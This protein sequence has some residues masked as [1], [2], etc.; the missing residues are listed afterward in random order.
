MFWRVAGFTQ[1]SPVETILD[2]EAFTL[3][4]LLEEDDLIQECKSLNGRL[5]G[6]LQT[7]PTV[8]T[9]L[10]YLV[11]PIAEDADQKRRFKYPFAACEVF[12]CEVDALFSTL[13]EDGDLMKQLLS[14]L[15][16]PGPMDCVQAGYF[17]RVITCVQVKRTQDMMR[18]LQANQEVLA[19]LVS[20]LETTSIAEVIARLVGAEESVAMHLMPQQIA[21][22]AETD[23]VSQLLEALRSAEDLDA[24]KN[25]ANVLAAIARSQLLEALRSAEDLDARKN[26]ANVLAA[27][28]RSQVSPLVQ[29]LVEPAI[30]ERLFEAAF[31]SNVS[32]QALKVCLALLEAKDSPADQHRS[33]QPNAEPDAAASAVHVFDAQMKAATVAGIV[34]YLP[35]L[36]DILD[37]SKAT[38]TQETPFGLLSPPLGL[39]RLK[40]VELAASI[41]HVKIAAAEE[42]LIGCGAA[43]VCMKLFLQF[44]FNN[45]LHQQVVTLI[46][47]ALANGSDSIIDH[48]F[49]PCNLVSWLATAPE[50]VTPVARANDPR[51]ESRPTVRAGYVGHLSQIANQ[52]VASAAARP[53]VQ[54]HLEASPQWQAYAETSLRKRNELQNVQSWACGRPSASELP[55]V[56][57]DDNE[58]V[59]Q[60]LEA[61]PDA[62]GTRHLHRYG[63]FGEDDEDDDDDE[64][65]LTGE[66][67]HG[68]SGLAEPTFFRGAADAFISLHLDNA[69][70]GPDS[71]S[72]SDSDEGLSPTVNQAARKMSG[73][74]DDAVVV[75]SDDDDE[76]MDDD[77][78]VVAGNPKGGGSSPKT[79]GPPQPAQADEFADFGELARSRTE[80]SG[81]GGLNEFNPF[82][83]GS[84]G[85][86]SGGSGGDP[87]GSFLPSSHGTPGFAAFPESASLP[88]PFSS[89]PDPPA[90]NAF[91][92]TSAGFA[93]FPETPAFDAFGQPAFAPQ[94]VQNQP[95]NGSSSGSG[96]SG[97]EPQA[98]RSAVD[99]PRIGSGEPSK[100]ID[101]PQ[102]PSQQEEERE[103]TA[104]NYWRNS[105]MQLVG[106]D[107]MIIS[108]DT[109]P[110]APHQ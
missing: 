63:S 43:D 108:P 72:S 15:D 38:G 12:C 5:I 37:L 31:S 51:A 34:R 49:G 92:E 32:M 42:A 88:S 10:K 25:S 83:E 9:L 73:I 107:D 85:V 91:P 89:F 59:L 104:F 110:R 20:H 76:W 2:K 26:S 103:F 45:L 70:G 19:K 40:A 84:A 81:S 79:R 95:A 56:G 17:A 4:E 71:S 98:D 66:L 13:L 62:T 36:L 97:P 3:E 24:R 28:A 99:L 77:A 48:L 101:I 69:D 53:K 75:T 47:S 86:S 1:P 29:N 61:M 93:A 68:T 74:D 27:I 33:Q 41:M 82:P 50:Q 106:D 64:H 80:R 54:A 52:I 30:L 94:P 100:A 67:E 57:S 8:Q 6:F 7:K 55:R 22:F 21:W 35:R 60:D 96:G 14:L 18:Y 87:F 105:P 65:D 39:A 102:P 16:A 46:N 90:F 44:P 58:H 78:V 11:D 23:L 109:Q